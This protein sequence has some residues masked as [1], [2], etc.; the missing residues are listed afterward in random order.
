MFKHTVTYEDFNGDIREETLY[1]NFSKPEIMMMNRKDNGSYVKKLEAIAASED[2][3][4][5]MDAFN[6]LLLDSYGIKSDDGTSFLK[7]EEIRD[8]FAQS[9]AYETILFEMIEKP[10]LIDAFM[11][12]VLPKD[13][14]IKA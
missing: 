5:I 12:G 4:L 11:T 3:M 2:P 8:K 14:D 9:I 7:S 6:D 10:E 1:F 13:L